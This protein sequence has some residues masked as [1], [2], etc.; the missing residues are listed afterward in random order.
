MLEEFSTAISNFLMA[1]YQH[2]YLDL[3]EAINSS[4]SDDFRFSI[5]AHGH[6]KLRKEDIGMQEEL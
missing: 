3:S 4:P 6:Q 5:S 2:L 1:Y